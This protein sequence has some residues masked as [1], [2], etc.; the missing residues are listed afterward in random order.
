MH[1]SQQWPLEVLPPSAPEPAHDPEAFPPEL[2]YKQLNEK[3]PVDAPIDEPVSVKEGSEKE[4]SKSKP[5]KRRRLRL[6]IT[7]AAVVVALAAVGLG[8][9]LSLGRKSR[10]VSSHHS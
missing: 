8:V 5:V 1:H 4:N 3:L 6:W 10:F 9:G 7:L 2:A